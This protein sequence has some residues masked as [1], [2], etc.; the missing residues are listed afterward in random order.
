MENI[1]K[2]WGTL[3]C[4]K[5]PCCKWG[6]DCLNY[7]R[8][9]A[10]DLHYQFQHVSVQNMLFDPNDD[11]AEKI[12]DIYYS[13]PA[14][15]G[16]EEDLALVGIVIPAES[17]MMVN[18]VLE[19]LAEVYF[20]MPTVFEGLMHGIFKDKKQADLARD[21]NIT[22]QGINKRM[23]REL[24][25]DQKRNSIQERRDREL[26][27]VKLKFELAEQLEQEKDQLIR[28]MSPNEFAVYKLCFIDGCSIRSAAMQL[29]IKKSRVHQIGQ[30]LRRKLDKNWTGVA[31]LQ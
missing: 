26:A 19:K 2:C 6:A 22:R 11:E 23:H 21:K 24:G 30:S 10:D 9:K 4:E 31:S 16:R 12:N 29:N 28:E 15:E 14:P 25:V 3:E 18:A 5:R 7:A 17:R 1:E 13:E 20:S 27:A 8:E